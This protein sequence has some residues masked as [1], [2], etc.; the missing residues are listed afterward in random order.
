MNVNIGSPVVR[1]CM[2]IVQH[3]NSKSYWRMRAEVVNP[4]SRVPKIVRYFYLFRIKR[5]DAF[6]CA[7]MGTDMGKGA[8]FKTP[9][10]LVHHL[11]GIII[12]HHAKIGAD[13]IIHQQ[14]TIGEVDGKAAV[15]GDNVMI[16]AG[17]KII[18][19]VK[20]GNNVK[21]GANAVV[22]KDV[23]DN[24]TAV[25]CPARIIYPKGE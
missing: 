11:N 16:G 14:V 13:C 8:E 15:I 4:N 5:M 23:P 19:P 18:G 25:G 9:P 12:S 10:R 20:I 24:C 7:S 17:A 3:Y 6:N 22:V 2:G 21:I 1:F